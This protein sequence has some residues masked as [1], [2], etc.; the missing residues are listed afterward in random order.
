MVAQESDA[1]GIQFV[2]ATRAFAAV[3]YQPGLLEDTQVLRN[4]RPRHRQS[5]SQF[6]DSARMM[7]QP[8]KDGEASG[9]AERGKA[10]LNVSAHLR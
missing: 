3:A 5:S 2:D 4:G 10:G 8:F 1:F 6:M 7:A 9:V